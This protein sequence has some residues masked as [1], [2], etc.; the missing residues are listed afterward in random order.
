MRIL[1]SGQRKY[2]LLLFFLSLLVCWQLVTD[3][4]PVKYDMVDCYYPWRYF[5][6]DCL[7]HGKFPYWNPYQNLG[8]PIHA[9][10]GSGTWYPL[11]WLIGSTVG[12]SL[13][14]LG[15][16]Y[17]FH[18]FF[19]GIGF[20]LLA[21]A[22]KF[23]PELAVLLALSYMLGGLFV[24][25]AQHLA[26]V[27][28]ACWMPFVLLF[29]LRMQDEGNWLDAL[30]TGFFLF[31]M[32]TGGYP[33]FTIVLF[34]LLLLQFS[35]QLI[36]HVRSKNGP[37]VRRWILQ[38]TLF[39]IVATL[40]SS[41]YLV[42]LFQVASYITRTNQFNLHS[43]LFGPFSPQSFLSFLLPYA[44]VK[45]AAWFDTDMSMANGYFGLLLFL[46]L[47]PSFFLKKPGRIR[48]FFWFGLFCLLASVGSY[49]P[50]RELL[51]R[52]VPMMNIFRFPS[53]FRLFAMIGFIFSAGYAL[54]QY[55]EGNRSELFRKVG[56]TGLLLAFV[57][58]LLPVFL[59]SRYP[60]NLFHFLQTSLFQNTADSTL[61]Q[62]LAV[63]SLFQLGM[64][65]LLILVL[66]ATLSARKKITFLLVLASADLLIA[67]QLNAPYT[68]FYP[69]FSTRAADLHIQKIGKEGFPFPADKLIAA[70]DPAPMYAEPFWKNVA[71]F[72]KEISAD[73]FNSFIFAGYETLRDS[74]PQLQ[75][76]MI[77]N[78]LAYLSASAF[79]ET[80]YR[81]LQKD[82]L[83]EPGT[84][85]FS[86][87]DYAKLPVGEYSHSPGDTV[88][89]KEFDTDRMLF[90]TSTAKRQL[91][92][93][94]Q[95][96][97]LGWHAM[98]DDKEVPVYTSNK[99][100][101]SIDLVAGTHKLCFYY[102]NKAVRAA[103]ILSLGMFF[104]I[105]LILVSASF[106][107][108]A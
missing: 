35:L 40:L 7:Q 68:V 76:Q 34:Y 66:R 24:G 98:I 87:A 28:S 50:F 64:L 85:V 12:Y 20:F 60:L 102:E 33:A 86:S 2:Y 25:N 47:I 95:C 9:D 75:Q 69:E 41:G 107:R 27:V 16:E 88:L 55:V 14:T 96:N 18:V 100:L 54:Q 91:L 10:P 78:K 22:L 39:S 90:Q 72:Q 52:F 83:F 92:T 29:Y 79:S 8:Y 53:I 26:Y 31:L 32:I 11:V 3:L 17:W 42:S 48:L 5:I 58:L 77:H 15:L 103:L 30:K 62:H 61:E 71:I 70:Q 106:R 97:Y 36:S 93:V 105:G 4:H 74:F 73:G 6:G 80:S 1:F 51:F 104:G 13:Y 67:A 63:Q 37:A 19:A 101:M 44:T 82:S 99:V 23:R 43:A 46:F 21:R 65:A 108:R 56:V 38:N 57:F 45:D 59:R 49:L 81:E 89:L 94:L 84:L